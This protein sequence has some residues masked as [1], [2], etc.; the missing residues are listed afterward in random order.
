MSFLGVAMFVGMRTTTGVMLASLDEYYKEQ[1]YYDIKIIST[2]GLTSD[3]VNSLNKLG[4]TSYGTHSKDVLTLLGE[5][6]TV[7][8]II[9]LNDKINKVLLDEGRL[10]QSDDEIVVEQN[11][12]SHK[13]KKIGDYYEID[14]DQSFKVHKFKIVGTVTSPMYLLVGG[15]SITRGN[16]NIGNGAVEFYAYTLDSVFNMDYYT[17]IYVKIDNDYITS[18][19]EYVDLVNDTLDKIDGIKSIREKARYDEIYNKYVKEID[20]NEAKGLKELNDA[21]NKLDTFKN[22]LDKGYSKLRA[23]KLEIDSGKKSLEATLNMLNNSR[24]ELEEGTIKLEQAKKELE[25]G[26]KEL[27]DALSEYGLTIDDI[28]TLR[29]LLNDRVVSKERLKHV[30]SESPYKDVIYKIIDYIYE[31]EDLKKIKEYIESNCPCFKEK[32]ISLIPKDVEN[33]DEIVEYITNLNKDILREDIY[34]KILDTANNI[35]D[36]KNSIPSDVPYRD[37]IIKLLD[38]YADTVIKIKELFDGVDSLIKGKEEIRKNE[39]LL[40]DG[41]IKLDN[42]YSEYY[43]Y[44]QQLKEGEAAYHRGY[45]DYLNSLNIYNSSIEEYFRNKFDFENKIAEARSKLTE[46]EMPEWYIYS[47]DDD[48]EYSGYIGVGD[49][50]DRLAATFPTIFFIVAVFMSIMSMSRMALEDRVEIGTLKSLGF[51]NKHIYLKYVLY[52]TIATIIGGILGGIFGFYFLTWFIFRMYRVLYCLPYFKYYYDFLPLILGIA[53]SVICITGSSVVTVRKIV[54]EKPSSLLRPL[55]PSSGK[56][57]ILEYLPIWKILS[58]SNKITIRNIVRYKK[59]VIMTVIGITGCTV[60]LLTGYGIRDAIRNIPQKQFGEVFVFDEIFYLDKEY[61]NIDDVLNNEHIVSRQDANMQTVKVKGTSSN[62]FAVDNL[63]SNNVIVR[64]YITNEKLN[65]EDGKVIITNKLLDIH[66]YNVGDKIE[67][68]DNNNKVHTAIV[69]GIANNYV[70]SYIFISKSY[71][72]DMFGKYIP[73]VSYV[74]LDSIDNEETVTVELMKNEHVL[75]VVKKTSMLESIDV[76][77]NPLD[78]IVVILLVLSGMLSFVVLYNLSYINISERKREIATLK[79]LGFTHGEVD[80]Y[81][82]KENFIITII[83][84]IVGMIVGK[85]FVDYIVDAIELD[86]VS[87]IHKINLDSYLF[88][89]MFMILFTCIV[90]VIIH[91]TLKK[92]NMIESLKTVE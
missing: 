44:E 72:E 27:T 88:T 54:T 21:K 86:L 10:P 77:L 51:S 18:S 40:R 36:I 76:M 35:E 90:T 4:V 62:L 5:D 15:N 63:D 25:N 19:K 12:L 24:I 38:N 55:A 43:K 26:E 17:E 32:I 22:E 23:S 34:I 87:F 11:F 46:I 13:G 79:V 42:G 9:G 52:S 37:N 29:E 47:R 8:K 83:G 30:F 65:L 89:F 61:D 66:N 16:T 39:E 2:L 60:L 75:S 1:N 3:D 57:I 81:I 84:I 71:Y 91:F 33:Y 6:T 74:S 70:G 45:K 92:I 68:T 7:T 82:I 20:E 80:N 59:R 31:T 58:F 69:S 56:K 64:D 49:S 53:I 50:I 41:K 85:P 14:D 48:S 78:Y 73:N 67:I 28:L